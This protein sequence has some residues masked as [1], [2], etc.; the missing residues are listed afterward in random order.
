[1]CIKKSVYVLMSLYDIYNGN[2]N[3]KYHLDTT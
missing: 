2:E 1:M 3:K